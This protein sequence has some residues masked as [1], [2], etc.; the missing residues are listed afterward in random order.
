MI[1]L[2]LQWAIEHHINIHSQT[3]YLFI[4]SNY[5]AHMGGDD[6]EWNYS[7][8]HLDASENSGDQQD[9]IEV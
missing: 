7:R 8:F 4:I 1:D 2:E 5:K 6:I 3:L 9:R